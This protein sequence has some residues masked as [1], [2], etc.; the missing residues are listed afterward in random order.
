MQRAAN[1]FNYFVLFH[2]LLHH[3]PFRVP[4]QRIMMTSRLLLNNNI[5]EPFIFLHLDD[6]SEDE[7]NEDNDEFVSVHHVAE[8]LDFNQVEADLES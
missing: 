1:I 3:L 6:A 8:Q 2:Q 4:Q 7:D 5:D